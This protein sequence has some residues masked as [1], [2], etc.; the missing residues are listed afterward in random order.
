MERT[1]FNEV[2]TEGLEEMGLKSNPALLDGLW[3][4]MNFLLEE[5]RKYNLTAIDREEEVI[6][7]HFL[8]SLVFFTEFKP[9]AG[10]RI[11]DMGTG[12][13]FPGLVLKLYQGDLEVLLVDSLQ[14]RVNFLDLLIKKLD[15]KLVEA[16]HGRA[17]D[18]G[19]Q[20]EYRERFDYVVS[21]AVAPVNILS[22]FTLPFLQPG[23]KA[24]YFKGPDYQEELEQGEKAVILLGGRLNT[25][26]QVKIPGLEVERFL[27]EIEKVE[28]TPD[29]YPRKAGIPKKRP[30]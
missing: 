6:T 18:L 11:L 27:I 20:E 12:A 24:V 5:N 16:L 4:Y 22:E 21:R 13:G 30:L 9:P 7:R 17:E 15:L 10:S 1:R 2:L 14:K 29:R 28:K 8:D 23:G 19:R 26:H 3:L 25:V